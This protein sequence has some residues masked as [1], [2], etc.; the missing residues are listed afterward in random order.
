[1]KKLLLALTIIIGLSTSASVASVN[2]EEPTP[3]TTDEYTVTPMFIPGGGGT[4]GN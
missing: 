1:M 2:A 4:G 3:K